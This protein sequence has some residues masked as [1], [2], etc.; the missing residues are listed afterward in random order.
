LNKLGNYRLQ[1][2]TADAARALVEDALALEEAGVFAVV[3]EVVPR[4]IARAVTEA[5][6][7]PTI[8][9]GAGAD[10]DAQILV[11]HDLLGLSFSKTS[12]R[13]VR[14]YADVRASM[15][16]AIQAYAD[17]VRAG[18]FPSDSESYPLPADAASELGMTRD[19]GD[20]ETKKS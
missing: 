19:A 12:P 10:C 5:L 20:K 16:D 14:R 2:K 8:G 17:D 4:E 9:I 13:F 7:V 6:H 3:L 15:S 1:A 18:T 11:T